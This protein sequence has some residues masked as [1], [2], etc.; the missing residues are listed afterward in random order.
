MY[1]RRLLLKNS[2]YF[3]VDFIYLFAPFVTH[4]KACYKFTSLRSSSLMAYSVFKGII[5]YTKLIML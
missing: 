4:S 3:N 1:T 5:Y 2:Q